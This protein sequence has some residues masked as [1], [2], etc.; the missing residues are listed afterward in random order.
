MRIRLGLAQI[1]TTVGD[2]EGNVERIRGRIEEAKAMGVDLIALPE[3]AVTGYPP[4]DLLLKPSFIAANRQALCSLVPATAGITAIVGF[5]DRE[6]DL[7]NAAAVLHD[8]EWVATYRKQRLPNYGVFD[9]LRYFLPSRGELLLTL[10]GVRIGVSICEDIWHPGGPVGR[11]ARAGADLVVNI[12]A[13]PYHRTKWRRRHDMLATRAT[14]YGVAIAYV[15][16]VGGQDELVFDGDSMIVDADGSVLAEA[17]VFEEH[18]LVHDVELE[19][20]FRQRLHDPRRRQTARRRPES[21]RSVELRPLPQQERPALP[22]AA[23]RRHEEITEVYAALVTGTRDYVRKNGF[24]HVVLGLS[25]GI[26]SAMVA[27]IAVDALGADAVTGVSMPSRY[28]SEHSRTDAAEL[29]EN[30]GIPLLQ[31]PIE[32]P[33]A[34]TLEAL[35]PVFRDIRADVTEENL[36]ARIRGNLLMALSNKFG[37]L[38]LTTGNKSEMATGYSTLYGD[39]AGGFAVLKDVPKT[40]VYELARWRSTRGAVIPEST[41]VKPPSAELRPDQKDVDSL[42]P[43][44][45]LDPILERYVEDDWSV[46]E[47]IAAGFDPAIVRRVVRLVDV[48]E[49][50]RRQAPPG[51]KVTD[52]AFGKDRRLPITSRFVDK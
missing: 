1:N 21:V 9:E 22:P 8:G 26:D 7:F 6:I 27:V 45:V 35:D 49:Y 33:F 48:N 12:N 34:A 51:V 32:G 16:Q 28:S 13:S 2:L 23:P 20:A 50:K 30:L 52:R 31:I 40:L 17:P 24:N 37:W 11:L 15:N 10:E 19:H 39:M 42:P 36:Q 4:E 14:D 47:L 18:L 46:T 5:V 29:A 41:L 44:E 43:Y 38:V 25:G 3:L